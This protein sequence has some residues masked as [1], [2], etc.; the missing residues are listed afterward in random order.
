M[1]IW[2]G[3]KPVDRP[4]TSKLEF[5]PNPKALTLQSALRVR[6]YAAS[7][8]VPID[9]ELGVLDVVTAIYDPQ[10]SCIFVVFSIDEVILQLLSVRQ[11]R[12]SSSDHDSLERQRRLPAL[13]PSLAAR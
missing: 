11:R 1:K 9:E 7:L 3:L 8:F 2:Y 12:E 5:L 4:E 13:A 10:I 6:L